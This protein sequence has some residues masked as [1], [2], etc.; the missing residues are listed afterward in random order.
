MEKRQ[1]KW[2]KS[3]ENYY[4][5]IFMDIQMPLMNGYEAAKAIRAL[6]RRDADLTDYCHD[7]ECIFR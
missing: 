6:H 5:L 1:W 4:D 3:P 2:W 7:G